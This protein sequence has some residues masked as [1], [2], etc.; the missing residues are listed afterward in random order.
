M[1]PGNSGAAGQQIV[2]VDLL[3]VTTGAAI[4]ATSLFIHTDKRAI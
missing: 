1:V 2:Q 4:Y 3:A